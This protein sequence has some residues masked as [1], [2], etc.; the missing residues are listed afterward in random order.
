MFGTN[1]SSACVD[2]SP[3]TEVHIGPFGVKGR[4]R[5]TDGVRWGTTA[6][7]RFWPAVYALSDGGFVG[8]CLLVNKSFLCR[9]NWFIFLYV[10]TFLLN[11]RLRSA[12]GGVDIQL[13]CCIAIK[14]SVIQNSMIKSSA[15]KSFP[16]KISA[17]KDPRSKFR[18][19]KF[20]DQK[21]RDK[22]FRDQ[23]S[24]IRVS[25]WKFLD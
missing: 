7:I 17:I 1:R 5:W 21:F 20:H 16:I 8:F 4:W 22:K 13:P 12:S 3:T 6:G 25:R 15:I 10:L 11:L 9:R 23:S 19:Q 14:S 2:R 18:D 24:A